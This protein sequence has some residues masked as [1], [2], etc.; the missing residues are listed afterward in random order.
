[1][2]NPP[3]LDKLVALQRTGMAKALS[4]QMDLPESQALSVEERL[5]LLGDREMTVRRERRLTTRLRQAKLRLRASVEDIDYRPPRG[6][7]TSLL[8]RLASCH[9]VHDRYNVLIT[10]PMGIGK[11]SPS[12]YSSDR[13]CML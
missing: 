4:E 2:L 10:G 3:T 1:M 7:D 9:W 5:G 8:L 6:L 13:D 11:S 12:N